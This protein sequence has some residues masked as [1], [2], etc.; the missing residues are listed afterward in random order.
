[1]ASRE[2]DSTLTAPELYESHLTLL[3]RPTTGLTQATFPPCLSALLAIFPFLTDKEH[4]HH[5]HH[6]RGFA[7][8]SFCLTLLPFPQSRAAHPLWQV[9]NAMSSRSLLSTHGTHPSS[10]LLLLPESSRASHSRLPRP[11]VHFLVGLLGTASFGGEGCFVFLF[12]FSFAMSK[13][14]V[15]KGKKL[16][17]S[18]FIPGTWQSTCPPRELESN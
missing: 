9:L 17:N 1:M 8:H 2:G 15:L 7:G 5:H 18:F 14:Q 3:A 6:P 12:S 10:H 11:H 13:I 4:H 16:P